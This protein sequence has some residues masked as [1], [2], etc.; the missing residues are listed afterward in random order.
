M[1]ERRRPQPGPG[2]R[3]G[4]HR[5]RNSTGSINKRPG[6]PARQTPAGHDARRTVRGSLYSHDIRRNTH[7]FVT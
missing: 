1:P 4:V 7:P 6:R 3:P 5:H 2:A